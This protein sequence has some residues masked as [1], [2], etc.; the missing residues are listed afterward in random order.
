[1]TSTATDNAAP[2]PGD[3]IQ[4]AALAAPFILTLLAAA[5]LAESM[6]EHGH[7][8]PRHIAW[9]AGLFMG[10]LLVAAIG[11]AVFAGLSRRA[12]GRALPF[13]A[14]Q[15]GLWLLVAFSGRFLA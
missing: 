13:V 15:V 11:I 12:S 6:I 1:M 4:K 10:L 7:R 9:R 14:A 2:F 8:D 5:A 3:P